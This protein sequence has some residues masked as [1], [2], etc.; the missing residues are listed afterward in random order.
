MLQK[1]NQMNSKING[2]T[3]ETREEIQKRLQAAENVKARK[4]LE[5]AMSH[6]Q[7]F[8]IVR[9]RVTKEVI[10]GTIRTK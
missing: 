5:L 10:S 1:V 8:D 9:E 3:S 7:A 4:L 6:M 2:V